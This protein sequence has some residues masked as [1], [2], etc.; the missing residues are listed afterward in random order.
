MVREHA[1][2]L[3]SYFRNEGMNIELLRERTDD[4]LEDYI[5]YAKRNGIGGILYF[6]TRSI[7]KVINSHSGEIQE[8]KFEDFIKQ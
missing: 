1:I 2:V 8:A 7:I 3:A 5:A 4:T 6:E